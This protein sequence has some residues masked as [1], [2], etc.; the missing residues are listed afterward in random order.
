MNEKTLEC[1]QKLVPEAYI[2][3]ARD[4]KRTFENKVAQLIEQKKWSEEGWSEQWIERF[5][6]EISMMDSNNF[7]KRC[8]VGERE[9]RVLSNMVARRHFRLIHGVGRSGFLTDVQPKAAGSSL[10]MKLTNHLATDA[11]KQLG[12][13]SIA[14]A[15]VL[16][17]ATG[18]SLMLCLMALKRGRG[19]ACVVLWSR[20]DQ[21]SCIKSVL[22]AGLKLK[23]VETTLEGDE[24]RTDLAGMEQAIMEVGVSNVVCVVSTT[25]CFAPRAPDKIEEVSVLC[26]RYNL[27]HLINNAYGLQSSKCMHLIQQGQRLGRVDY[28]VQSTDKNFMVPVGGAIVAAFDPVLISNICSFYPGRASINSHLDLLITLLGVGSKAF[29]DLL[30]QRKVSF[31]YLKKQLNTLASKFNERVLDSPNNKISIG[32]TLDGLHSESVTQVGSMLFKR[33]VSGTRVIKRGTRSRIEGVTLEGFGASHRAY[34]SHY[35]T[36]AASIGISINDIDTF[37]H[38]LDEV[39]TRAHHTKASQLAV[40][41]TIEDHNLISNTQDSN[42]SN[43]NNIESNVVLSNQIGSVPKHSVCCSV[44][45]EMK[46]LSLIPSTSDNLQNKNPLKES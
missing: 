8:Q 10:L 18:M 14:S 23:V 46:E 33:L 2:N 35:L 22:A 13:P 19:E 30:K 40:D 7:S 5:L 32:L 31:E 21:K 28:V 37:I 15:I 34:P 4:A 41:N 39:L 43:K 38:R 17:M 11:L 29:K 16:P 25:S 27:P 12:L 26:K 24:I 6:E 20:I 42:L 3:Q 9:G 36:A 44:E 45:A 1:C